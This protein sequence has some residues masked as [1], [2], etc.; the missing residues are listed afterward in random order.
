MNIQMLPLCLEEKAA[1][2][3]LEKLMFRYRVCKNNNYKAGLRVTSKSTRFERK[4]FALQLLYSI[5]L[6]VIVRDVPM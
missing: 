5:L 4:V 1:L 6:S 3:T 2:T